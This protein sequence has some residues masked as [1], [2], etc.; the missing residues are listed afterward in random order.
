[1]PRAPRYKTRLVVPPQPGTLGV[2]CAL[3]LFH[4]K[5][6]EERKEERRHRREV[7]REPYGQC[8]SLVT[9]RPIASVGECIWVL[10]TCSRERKEEG[11]RRG[12]R[13]ARRN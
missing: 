4:P 6:R 12:L 8:P 5:P 10:R 13:I 9:D 7:L 11:T 3:G 2:S 1:M